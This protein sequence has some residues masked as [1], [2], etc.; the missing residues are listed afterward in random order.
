VRHRILVTSA[1]VALAGC[2][3]TTEPAAAMTK[4]QARARMD[5]AIAELSW[6]HRDCWALGCRDVVGSIQLD[7]AYAPTYLRLA[8]K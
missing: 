7:T 1:L 2:G 3:D 6:A 4:E 5:Q 8:R